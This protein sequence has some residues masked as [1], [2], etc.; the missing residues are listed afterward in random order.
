MLDSVVTAKLPQNSANMFGIRGNSKHYVKKGRFEDQKSV[1]Y[2]HNGRWGIKQSRST[3][4]F[5][6]EGLVSNHYCHRK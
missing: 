3:S 5:E 6:S 2:A 1:S 4:H